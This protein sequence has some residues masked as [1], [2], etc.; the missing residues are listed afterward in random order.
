MIY[1]TGYFITLGGFPISGN[2]KIQTEISL[3]ITEAEYIA[4]SQAMPELIPMRRLLLEI[5]VVM[6]LDGGDTAVIK[7]TVFENN[8]GSLTTANDVKMTPHTKNIG[9]KCHL[10]KHHCD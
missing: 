4:L 1:R 8:N 3:S 9:V 7:S 10:F 6:K 5:A 2:S